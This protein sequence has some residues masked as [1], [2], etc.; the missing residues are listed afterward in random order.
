MDS[1]KRKRKKKTKTFMD[2]IFDSLKIYF[3][4]CCEEWNNFDFIL[5]YLN[6]LALQ[7]L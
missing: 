5:T 4:V 6:R 2:S 7:V 1:N 3:G